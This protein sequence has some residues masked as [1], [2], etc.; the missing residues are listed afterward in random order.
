M[1]TSHS[2]TEDTRKVAREW[3]EAVHNHDLHKLGR[4]VSDD[5]VDHSGIA[6]T[7]GGGQKGHNAMV[8]DLRSAFPDL[9]LQV[10]DIL[11]DGDRA[12]IRYRAEATPKAKAQFMAE[13]MAEPKLEANAVDMI[14]VEGGK[15]VEH[16]TERAPFGDVG[17]REE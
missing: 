15:I 17:K 11:A 2:Q 1:A 7:Y 4:L 16:W 12:V 13:E 5:L 3:I 8:D 14:R 10:L 6:D 9:K